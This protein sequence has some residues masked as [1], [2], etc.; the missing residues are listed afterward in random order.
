[1]TSHQLWA[2]HATPSIAAVQSAGTSAAKAMIINS[3]SWLL[4]ALRD[5]ANAKIARIP[6]APAAA[7]ALRLAPS[8]RACR[9]SPFSRQST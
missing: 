4:P 8:W 6:T 7:S 1:M 5:R 3:A 9:A 2:P